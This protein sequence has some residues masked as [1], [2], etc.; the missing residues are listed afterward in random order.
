MDPTTFGASRG[1]KILEKLD[2]T[3][4][5]AA[6]GGMC[7]HHGSQGQEDTAGYYSQ[8]A[9]TVTDGYLGRENYVRQET[10]PGLVIDEEEREEAA[11]Y[12]TITLHRY[13]G[14][15]AL[16]GYTGPTF[17]HAQLQ[18]PPPPPPPPYDH[19][20]QPRPNTS[21]PPLILNHQQ[22]NSLAQQHNS[23]AQ[24]HNS[25]TQQHDDSIEQHPPTIGGNGGYDHLP[26]VGGSD[27]KIPPPEW[28]TALPSLA[29]V[30][31][32]PPPAHQQDWS[33]PVLWRVESC[34]D[35]PNLQIWNE[36][37]QDLV[38][39][40]FQC[41]VETLQ[42]K[43]EADQRRAIETVWRNSPRME[44]VEQ[45]EQME[46]D[47]IDNGQFGDKVVK[48]PSEEEK[49]AKEVAR[50]IRKIDEA[51]AKAEETVNNC[52]DRKEF[53]MLTRQASRSKT[54]PKPKIKL[55]NSERC[56]MFRENR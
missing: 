42:E 39:I 46:G 53:K 18:T 32:A 38:S 25:L 5:A 1:E 24:Q 43:K 10:E 21:P 16:A 19:Y 41:I 27:F 33:H 29:D 9:V 47:D 48:G 36:K 12:E 8:P 55:S 28:R 20:Q 3:G 14:E 54:E 52:A 15:E 49:K 44:Q 31:P 23:L 35:D 11:R 56:R 37:T 34:E 45:M 26:P 40:P 4:A 30:R 7:H 22:H 51:V 13:G 17:Y 50:C 6:Y 2:P